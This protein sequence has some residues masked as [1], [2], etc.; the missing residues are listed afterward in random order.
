MFVRK[1]L[2][3]S[4][5]AE[6]CYGAIKRCDTEKSRHVPNLSFIY[7]KFLIELYPIVI[8][9]IWIQMS[10]LSDIFYIHILSNMPEFEQKI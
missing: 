7:T 8:K 3:G 1:L 2:Q 6:M 9:K 5:S 4:V 10:L